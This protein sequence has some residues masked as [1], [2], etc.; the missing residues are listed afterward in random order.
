MKS[1]VSISLDQVPASQQAVLQR[2]SR[3]VR[4]EGARGYVV[5]GF[6]RDHLVGKPT[7]DI[8]LVVDGIAP[9]DV[10]R[11]LVRTLGLSGPIVYPRFK[12]VLAVGAGLEVE[13]C[14][15]EGDLA[16]D[17]SRRD[18]TINCLYLDLASLR[19]TRGGRGILDPTGQGLCDL[20]AGRLRAPQDACRTLWLDPLRIL[21]AVRFFAA[22]GFRLD[23]A[24]RDAMDRMAYLVTKPA[25]ERI[26]TELERILISPRLT[27]ALRLMQRTGINAALLP[28]L[29]QTD[30]FLQGTPYH[31][32][33]LFTHL[34]KTAARMPPVVT[35]RLAGLLH[36]VGKLTTQAARGGRMVYYGHEDVSRQVAAAVAKRLRFSNQA[37]D[38]VVFLAGNHMVNYS[39]AWSDRAVRRFVRRMGAN[40]EQVLILAEADRRAQRPVKAR[41]AGVWDLRKRVQRL[42][43]ERP[44]GNDLP[45]DGRDIMRILGIAQG[46]RVGEA[47]AFLLDEALKRRRRMTRA[48]A[49]GLLL[50]W[51]RAGDLRS[52]SI[53]VD[54]PPPA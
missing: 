18:F 16:N 3:L 44:A 15:L 8:D 53:H 5:G 13:I 12:T 22:Y 48:E 7:S 31:A 1:R 10:A 42:E 33:D 37:A 47:K 19:P 49:A 9:R 23:P 6:L 39:R 38:L 41:D 40:L 45:V 2:V 36:D 4:Q 21:R 35:L 14:K 11:V 24:L 17:A 34:A 28:E 20:E 43:N 46:P 25:V 50:W 51:N 32:Y 54:K 29:A 26:R 30:G 52:A 27:P